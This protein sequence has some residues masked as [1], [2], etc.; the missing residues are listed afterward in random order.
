MSNL[1]SSCA[2]CGTLVGVTYYPI[3]NIHLCSDCAYISGSRGDLFSV[4]DTETKNYWDAVNNFE[5]DEDTDL[6]GW[7][8]SN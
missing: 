1:I 5:T 3:A 7:Q 4:E 6:W 8:T 2:Q